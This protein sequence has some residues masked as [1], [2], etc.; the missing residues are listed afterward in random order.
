MVYNP[1]ELL[2]AA[3][4]LR[5]PTTDSRKLQLHLSLILETSLMKC[6]LL[7]WMPLSAMGSRALKVQ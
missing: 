5:W 3:Q 4:Q 2:G 6:G 1:A 7:W